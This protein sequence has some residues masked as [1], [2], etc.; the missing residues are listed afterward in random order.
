MRHI[1]WKIR[2]SEGWSTGVASRSGAK[3]G[4]FTPC[5]QNT[6]LE[7]SEVSASMTEYFSRPGTSGTVGSGRRHKSHFYAIPME[8]GRNALPEDLTL[9]HLLLTW[10]FSPLLPLNMTPT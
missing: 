5:W 9:L 8:K 2:K 10:D 6:V 4:L 3:R 7:G 1:R